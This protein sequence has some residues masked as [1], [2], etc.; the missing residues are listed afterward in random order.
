VTASLCHPPAHFP[1]PYVGLRP[2]PYFTPHIGPLAPLR[3]D[4]GLFFHA[5]VLFGAIIRGSD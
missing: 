1:F 4:R 5:D 3:W 2:Q